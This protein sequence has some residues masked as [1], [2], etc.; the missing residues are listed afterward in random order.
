MD[1][2]APALAHAPTHDAEGDEQERNA[3]HVHPANRALLLLVELDERSRVEPARPH[4]EKRVVEK[5]PVEQ[6]QDER[7]VSRGEELVADERGAADDGD[8]AFCR[9]LAFLHRVGEVRRELAREDDDEV[10]RAR[11][12]GV[13]F[14]P[15]HIL[16]ARELA[17]RGGLA[18]VE[19]IEASFAELT[20]DGGRLPQ[21]ASGERADKRSV[22]PEQHFTQPPP[23]YT[24]ATLVKRMEE[25]GIGRPSTY[26]SI[27]STIQEREYVR[28]D[29]NLHPLNTDFDLYSLGRDGDSKLPLTAATSRDDI[30]RA[31]NGAFIG[32]AENYN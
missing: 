31:N 14:M 28:K 2:S 15:G 30:L 6:V 5:E 13:D 4:R 11:F 27:V 32:R 1:Q 29:K 9:L 24:E 3:E 26:A 20:E 21:I 7:L 8:P 25:L 23:R 22:T 17:A 16:A 18:N 10:P 19:L 12:V